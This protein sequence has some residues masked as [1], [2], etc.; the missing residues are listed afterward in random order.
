MCTDL[1]LGLLLSFHQVAVLLDFLRVRLDLSLL[2][3]IPHFAPD[4][5]LL[6]GLGPFSNSDLSRHREL[7]SGEDFQFQASCD[8]SG[9]S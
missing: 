9:C 4:Q 8:G 5:A 7:H 1:F 3:R 2:L 6:A